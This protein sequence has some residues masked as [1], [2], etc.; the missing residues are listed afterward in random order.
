MM[1]SLR[2]CEPQPSKNIIQ[3]EGNQLTYFFHENLFVFPFYAKRIFH[4]QKKS[5]SQLFKKRRKRKE[6]NNDDNEVVWEVAERGANR[7]KHKNL[8]KVQNI[9]FFLYYAKLLRKILVCYKGTS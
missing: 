5:F 6:T 7:M 9:I 2:N 8:L 3:E 1:S 4:K